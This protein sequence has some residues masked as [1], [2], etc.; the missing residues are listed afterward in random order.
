MQQRML[1]ID[2]EGETHE[3]MS[4][5]DSLLPRIE[6]E[7]E[8]RIEH[9]PNNTYCRVVT[10]G[11]PIIKTLLL[12]PGQRQQLHLFETEFWGSQ[13]NAGNQ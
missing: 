11:E 10:N 12:S 9:R 4:M 2:F 13:N 6:Y 7:R 8:L 1:G 5:T 3:K